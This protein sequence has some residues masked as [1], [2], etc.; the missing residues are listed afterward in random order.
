[1]ARVRWRC[2]TGGPKPAASKNYFKSNIKV[3]DTD[4]RRARKILFLNFRNC[5]LMPHPVSGRGAY[6]DRHGTR[7]GDAVGVSGCSVISSCG[8]TTRCDGEIVWSWRPDAGAK[9]A[10]DDPVDDGG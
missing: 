6:R 10:G 8:R 5:V 2:P 1:M 3:I 7:G 9:F 4:L